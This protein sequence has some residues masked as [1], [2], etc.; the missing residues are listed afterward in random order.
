MPT[1]DPNP[2]ANVGYKDYHLVE[3]DH[4][5]ATKEARV[6]GAAFAPYRYGTGLANV[7]IKGGTIHRIFGGSNTKGNIRET[8]LTL[9]EEAED[10][11]SV[12]C[13]FHVDEAYGG[14]KSAPMDAEAKLLM[15]CIP[16]LDAVYGGAED[17]DIHGDVE[18]TITNGTFNSVFGGG[19]A[20]PVKGNT[21]VNIGT[22]L[23]D[24]IYIVVPVAAGTD[25]TGKGY[26]TKSG[27]DYVTATGE[28]VADTT[29]YKKYTVLGVDIRDNIYGG[30]NNA[31]VTGKT[32]VNIGKKV[33]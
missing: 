28:A 17:A 5:F 10:G 13:P 1:C 7:E 19:N 6:S 21:T 3:N 29:Y 2:G 16:G 31:E 4:A 24:D 11:G 14:G 12:V 22:A 33:M 15:A 9:L 18:L 20:A 30:G 23:G 25:L 8:A 32:N 26:Y 27:N